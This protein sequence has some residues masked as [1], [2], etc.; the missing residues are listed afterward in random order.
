MSTSFDLLEAQL[1]A[2]RRSLD[3]VGWVAKDAHRRVIAQEE[4]DV[5]F[6]TFKKNYMP[7]MLDWCDANGKDIAFVSYKVHGEALWDS[8]RRT[9]ARFITTYP[10]WKGKVTYRSTHPGQAG[11]SVWTLDVRDMA[12]NQAMYCLSSIRAMFIYSEPAYIYSYLVDAFPKAPRPLLFFLSSSM[13]PCRVDGS[14][15][16]TTTEPTGHRPSD[17]VVGKDMKNWIDGRGNPD[18][19]FDKGY[20]CINTF[21]TDREQAGL[22]LTNSSDIGD[23]IDV[24]MDYLYSKED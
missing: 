14:I 13:T 17:V 4:T 6:S 15:E 11:G 2:G 24:I 9:W 22:F 18:V 1:R 5:C 16:W 23:T 8:A 19:P 20:S 7:A 12:A 21:A 10:A 3:R